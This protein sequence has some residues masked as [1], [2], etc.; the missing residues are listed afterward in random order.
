MGTINYK[1]SKYV[2]LAIEPVDYDEEE[3]WELISEWYADLESEVSDLID[4]YE[5]KYLKVKTVYGYYEGFSIDI[6][7]EFGIDWTGEYW[8][9]EDKA[10]AQ[11]EIT[12]LKGLLY[13]LLDMG[14]CV[15]TPSWCTGYCDPVESRRRIRAGIKEMREECKKADTISKYY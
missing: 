11:K 13:R 9:W 7:D 5:F 1:T 10:D 3:D 2:T 6:E 15:C 8:N 14:L 4:E 12:R